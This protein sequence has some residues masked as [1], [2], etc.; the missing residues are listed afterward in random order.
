MADDILIDK[1]LSVSELAT[2]ISRSM[3]ELFYA[4]SVEGEVTNF[5][6]TGSSGHWY[7]SLKDKDGSII[8]CTCFRSRNWKE[9]M[10]ENGE[11][12]ILTG[13]LSFWEK[14]GAL[15]FNA[16]T[17]RRRGEGDIRALIEERRK[18]Y[19]QLGYFDPRLKKPLPEHVGRIGVVTSDTGAVIK[20]II[21]NT[22][23]VPGTTIVI[24]PCQVQGEGSENTIA[25]RIRQAN[26]FSACDVLIVGR[27][28]GSEEDLLP[29]SSEAVIEAI[30]ESAIPVIS[31]VGHE[32]D[33]P[34]SDFVA[35]MRAST[36]TAAAIL[37]TEND[38]RRMEN[39][40]NA[41]KEIKLLAMERMQRSSARLH[42]VRLRPES[43]MRRLDSAREVLRDERNLGSVLDY[44]IRN[45]YLSIDYSTESQLAA[46][47]SRLKA[48]RETLR[49][50]ESLRETAMRSL[51][52][53]RKAAL[54]ILMDGASNLVDTMM[55]KKR[56][57]LESLVNECDALDPFSILERGYA[58]IMDKDGLPIGSAAK[59][60]NGDEIRIKMKDGER[61][62]T[63]KE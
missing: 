20:D 43:L 62:A 58:I 56:N 1:V 24:F 39:F 52:E 23:R 35:D 59:M 27:G 49:H 10:P 60:A 5:R 44:R 8:N 22:S 9:R 21:R 30:H 42:A 36:P 40:R 31:A 37:A 25:M 48:L 3:K 34:I 16:D 7:F 11:V 45:S 63:V 6:K 12:V 17:I 61:T 32:N 51:V 29:Y 38:Y 19:E 15:S 2:L 14:G 57:A 28:G 54:S 41:E 53:K 55:T 50:D 46:M 4:L 33:W 26:I 13:S 47:Q 18:K